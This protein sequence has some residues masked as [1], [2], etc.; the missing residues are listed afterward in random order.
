MNETHQCENTTRKKHLYKP[1]TSI[2]G[3][4][5]NANHDRGKPL[6]ISVVEQGALL[7]HVIWCSAKCNQVL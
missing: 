7:Y 3:D 4:R 2:V 1:Y 5:G 6:P